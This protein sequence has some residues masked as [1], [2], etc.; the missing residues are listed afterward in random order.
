LRVAREDAQQL[1]PV[2]GPAHDADLIITPQKTSYQPAP[3]N[4]LNPLG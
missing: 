2:T 1:I 3:S 4:A